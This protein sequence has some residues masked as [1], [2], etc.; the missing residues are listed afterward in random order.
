[1]SDRLPYLAT[2]VAIPYERLTALPVTV[3]LENVRSLYNVGSFF[4]TM[5]AAGCER[6]YLSGITGRPPKRAITKTALGAEESIPWVHAPEPALLIDALRASGNE[7]A[8]I[9]TR[10]EQGGL[11]ARLAEGKPALAR[12]AA[13]F[14]RCG[15][16]KR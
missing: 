16:S 10:L 11:K 9:E 3:V 12:G 8:A 13:A 1:M 4:R 6:L 14:A 2:Q 7:I 15:R 5:D